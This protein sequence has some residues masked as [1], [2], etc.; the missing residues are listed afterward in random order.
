MQTGT[1]HS[2]AMTKHF[3]VISAGKKN[4]EKLLIHVHTFAVNIWKLNSAKIS[5]ALSS[6]QPDL[7]QEHSRNRAIFCCFSGLKCWYPGKTGE[8]SLIKRQRCIWEKKKKGRGNRQKHPR[9]ERERRPAPAK[10]GDRDKKIKG[11]GKLGDKGQELGR[12]QI[13][14]GTQRI[15]KQDRE[16]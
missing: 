4:W 9:L 14:Q 5:H 16:S 15:R 8:S 7:P 6:L 11:K 1:W 13:G 10:A 12:D 3:F 2:S